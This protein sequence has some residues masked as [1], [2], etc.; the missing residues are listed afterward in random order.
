PAMSVIAR[1]EEKG[2]QVRYH[3]PHVPQYTQDGKK[4][5]SVDLTAE[6]LQSADAVIV[7]SG[8]SN[9]DYRLVAEQSSLILDTRNVFGASAPSSVIKL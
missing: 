6:E 8:H 9:V 3:D 5:H 1:I 2:A 4:V 7:L